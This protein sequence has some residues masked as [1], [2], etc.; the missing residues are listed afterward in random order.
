MAVPGKEQTTPIAPATGT[1]SLRMQEQI[2]DV[3]GVPTTVQA[4]VVILTDRNGKLFDTMYDVEHR[5]MV[6]YSAMELVKNTF[7]MMAGRDRGQSAFLDRRGAVG[8]GS[9][10]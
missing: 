10:R 5:R 4:E 9:T 6:E 1:Q 2:V 7:R 3:A 8:R